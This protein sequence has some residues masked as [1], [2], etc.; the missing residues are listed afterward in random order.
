MGLTTMLL[1]SEPGLLS[2]DRQCATQSCRTTI[3]REL[4]KIGWL[5]YDQ[6]ALL[7]ANMAVSGPEQLPETL[8]RVVAT[9]DAL[10]STLK[11]AAFL[12][13]SGHTD[14][15]AATA[16]LRAARLLTGSGRLALAATGQHGSSLPGF[17]RLHMLEN[18]L[19]AARAGAGLNELEGMPPGL[20]A[21]AR[22][23]LLPAD[24]AAWLQLMT[25]R[26]LAL[27]LGGPMAA[28]MDQGVPEGCLLPL[29]WDPLARHPGQPCPFLVQTASPTL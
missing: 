22:T 8:F 23:A 9:L 15:R 5:L 28:S 25:S 10:S 29:L 20:L 21:A 26:L 12:S 6:E 4:E 27:C 17:V 3:C 13:G 11:V 14:E 18:H 19:Q 7:Q 16:L 1:L 2:E 24:T